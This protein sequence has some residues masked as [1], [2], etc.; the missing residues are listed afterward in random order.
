MGVSLR[1]FP[2]KATPAPK[3]GMQPRKGIKR[4]ALEDP[5]ERP[6]GLRTVDKR[7][8][9]DA[10]AVRLAPFFSSFQAWMQRLLVVGRPTKQY[11][12]KSSNTAVRDICQFLHAV[13]MGRVTPLA[14]RGGVAARGPG[15]ATVVLSC[16]L[17]CDDLPEAASAWASGEI[18]DA[19]VDTFGKSLSLGT[20]SVLRI[21]KHLHW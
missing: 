15:F 14:L 6:A 2:V 11:D 19:R 18:E 4:K 1:K 8:S 16:V 9:T 3:A 13:A 20:A 10:M 12:A 17:M 21:L 5:E 7:A